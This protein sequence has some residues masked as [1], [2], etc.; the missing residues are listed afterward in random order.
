[1]KNLSELPNIGN[2]VAN[3]LKQVGIY[4]RRFEIHRSRTSMAE[5]TAN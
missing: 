4:Y 5:N 2:A 1:M 3:Q